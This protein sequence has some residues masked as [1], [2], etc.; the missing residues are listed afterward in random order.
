[1]NNRSGAKGPRRLST[2]IAS[3]AGKIVPELLSVDCSR[4]IPPFGE[5]QHATSG[6]Q[7][8]P[9]V[10]GYLKNSPCLLCCLESIFVKRICGEPR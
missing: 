10:L 5:L 8:P 1:M 7:Q 2:P 9:F 4:D 6:C 3:N